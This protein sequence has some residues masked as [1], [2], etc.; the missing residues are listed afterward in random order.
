MITTNM[1]ALVQELSALCD[2][3]VRDTND[4]IDLHVSKPVDITKV[5]DLVCDALFAEP[6]QRREDNYGWTIRM[7]KLPKLRNSTDMHV[8]ERRGTGRYILD[9]LD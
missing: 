5:D 4:M 8:E 1:P 7:L 2:V 6:E 9:P 3:S